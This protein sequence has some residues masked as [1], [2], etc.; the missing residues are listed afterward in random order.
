MAE[1][2]PTKAPPTKGMER[3]K[4]RIESDMQMCRSWIDTAKNTEALQNDKEA[5]AVIVDKMC[6]QAREAYTNFQ[7]DWMGL[8]S[9]SES[10]VQDGVMQSEFFSKV[11][12][13]LSMISQCLDQMVKKCLDWH[14]LEKL[15]M[16]ELLR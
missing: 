11:D 1:A 2:T 14:A 16:A 3:L 8:L 9:C 10:A 6:R 12:N 7:E 4:A 5:G 13:E 15:E